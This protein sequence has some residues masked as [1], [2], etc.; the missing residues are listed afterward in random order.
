MHYRITYWYYLP[1]HTVPP[2]SANGEIQLHLHRNVFFCLVLCPLLCPSAKAVDITW[3][4]PTEVMNS[5]VNWPAVNGTYTQNCGVA[6]TTGGS[7]PFSMDWIELE[8][9]TS[10]VTA[11]AASLTIAL[12]NTNNSTAYS[13]VAS[14]TEYAKDI[15]TFSMPTSTHTSFKL[16]LTAAQ[17][18]N[19]SAYD[20]GSS[21][22]YALITYAPSVNIGMMR[23]TGYA[24]G[25]TNNFYTTTNGF[26]PLDT[27][28]NNSAN[29][30]SGGSSYPTLGI[31]FGATVPEPSTWAMGGLATIVLGFAARRKRS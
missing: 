1:F 29:Y 23:K 11:G 27:F 28:R 31:S 3:F 13:A 12:R 22:T 14:T 18:P 16:R 10:G 25:T 24:N 4:K 5:N 17:I 30:A 7:G 2:L 6:F 15:V 9:N 8:L 20:M 26:I 21:S 19:I